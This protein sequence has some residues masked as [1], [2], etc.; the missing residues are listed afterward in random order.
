MADKGGA[1]NKQDMQTLGRPEIRAKYAQALMITEGYTSEKTE[2]AYRRVESSGQGATD[3]SGQWSKLFGLWTQ[4]IF[5]GDIASSLEAGEAQRQ[6]GESANS[7][8]IVAAAHRQIATSLIISGAFLEARTHAERASGLYDE[9]TAQSYRT[10]TGA[11]F[12]VVLDV[13]LAMTMWATGEIETSEQLMEG[14][15]RRARQVDP[16]RS[17]VVAASGALML[18]GF[19]RRAEAA[20]L[21]ADE[22][23]AVAEANSIGAWEPHVRLYRAWAYAR[24][25]DPNAGARDMRAT[26]KAMQDRGVRLYGPVALAL[27]ADLE[28]A[29]GAFD[30]ALERIDEG[31]DLAASFGGHVETAGFHRLR[32]EILEPRDRAAAEQAYCESIAI[33]RTQGARTFEL[34]AAL[35]LAKLYQ[36]TNRPL[37]AHDALAPAL[38]GFAP[39]PE[40]PAIAE[41]QA[42]LAALAETPEVKQATGKR[43]SQAELFANYTRALSLGKGY[44]HAETSAAA[45]RARDASGAS[46]HA[47]FDSLFLQTITRLTSGDAAAASHAAETMLREAEAEGLAS[48]RLTGLRVLGLT[49]LFQGR[50]VDA[51]ALLTR[52]LE[53]RERGRRRERPNP[54]P[55]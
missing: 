50:L 22:A 55:A 35:S 9:A 44:G 13:Y 4:S 40:F 54:I 32:G 7:P 30:Q 29:R 25:K 51:D 26:W 31:L 19:G 15:I 2:A 39:T 23:L 41:A 6:L 16:K 38:E 47:H 21:I 45:A 8:T 24:L 33:A 20:L 3:L 46:S 49:R 53:S 27:M 37:D 34:Q 36:S 10:K 43:Q 14:S 18:L 1:P 48:E 11:D 42:L 12:R 5:K 52:A 28:F 17:F